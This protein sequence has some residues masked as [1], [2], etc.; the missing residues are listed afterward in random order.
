MGI[1]VYIRADGNSE[2]GLGHL[3]RCFALAQMLGNHFQMLFVCKS[4]PD[5]MVNEI[6]GLGMKVIKIDDESLFLEQLSANDIVVLDH[7]GLYSDYQKKIKAIGSKLVCIDDIHDKEFFADLIINH[8]F[9]ILATQ[10][11]AQPY[12]RFALGLDYALLRPKFVNAASRERSIGKI[13]VVFICF[14]GSDPKNLTQQVLDVVKTYDEITKI[15]VVIGSANIHK[16]NFAGQENGKVE[17]YFSAEEQTMFELMLA[18]DLAIVPSS[19]ILLEVLSAGCKVISG[20]YI[21]NQQLVFE[22]LSGAGGIIPAYDFSS[23]YVKEAMDRLVFEYQSDNKKWVDGKSGERI[24]KLFLDLEKE[25]KM[26]LRK[27]TKF[28]L[29]KTYE[30]A[31]DKTIR[32][33]SFNQNPILFEEH[34]NWFLKKVDQNECAYY[35][36]EIENIP[37][38]SIRFDIRDNQATISYLLDSGFH[39]KGLGSVLLKKG[40]EKF[41]GEYAISEIIGYV[42]P[43]NIA[44]VKAFERLGF[45]RE[46]EGVN[47]KYYKKR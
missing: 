39:N 24:L 10:Y 11:Q 27:G 41:A 8:T 14:G 25:F 45:V 46:V 40:V 21:D 30:W 26:V 38:G 16:E 37:I 7:Y 42:M 13:E 20:A 31:A 1:N 15:F 22:S 17:F 28:D 12:T 5:A 19:G 43:E 3:V 47:Y 9:G 29:D 32:A 23:N 18:S 4:I 2:I 36:A 34:S 35:I 6:Q 33:F 44:S